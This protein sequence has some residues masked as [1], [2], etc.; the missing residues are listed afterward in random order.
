MAEFHT[1]LP[2]DGLWIDMNE[3]ANFVTG[4]VTVSNAWLVQGVS[5]LSWPCHFLG[6]PTFGTTDTPCIE[7]KGRH[8]LYD[9]EA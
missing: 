5:E 6:F 2:W 1:R 4:S 7:K 9:D 3:P 8:Y